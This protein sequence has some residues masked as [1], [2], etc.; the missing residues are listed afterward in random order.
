MTAEEVAATVDAYIE[1][2]KN[3]RIS[4]NIQA[5]EL[6]H[7]TGE[8]MD[9]VTIGKLYRLALPDYGVTVEDNI[10]SIAWNDVYGDPSSVIV[11]LGAEEDT[12]VTFL[13]NL[14][15]KGS[16]GGG[17]GGA[18]KKEEEQ[19]KEYYTQWEKTDRYISAIAVHQNRQGEILE[20]AGLELNSDGLLVYANTSNGIYHQFRV[21]NDRFV[22]T[23]RDVE[24]GVNSQILQL[25]DQI[26]LKVNKGSVVSEINIEPGGIRIRANKIDIDGIVTSL[27]SYNLTA[28]K[29]TA[30]VGD[31]T[32]CSIG[33]H[34]AEWKEQQVVTGISYSNSTSRSFLYGTTSSPSGTYSGHVVSS[35]STTTLHYLSY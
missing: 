23:I 28:I 32:L 31:F 5:V 22:S 8:S 24:E 2:H 15:A 9:K 18:K 29:M 21:M 35:Y 7:I 19:W 13:H 10:T 30:G 27:S 12:V 33:G 4:V 3:P 14:D 6:C 25:K 26:R 11:N 1:D 17:G 34:T 20:Q 16:G